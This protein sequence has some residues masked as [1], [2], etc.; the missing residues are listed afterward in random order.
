MLATV[1]PGLI[2]KMCPIPHRQK[3]ASTFLLN[4]SVPA[5]VLSDKEE[6]LVPDDTVSAC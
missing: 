4:C 6:N 5:D 3:K 2:M 1:V